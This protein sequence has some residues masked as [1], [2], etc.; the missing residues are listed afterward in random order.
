MSGSARHDIVIEEGATFVLSVS[1]EDAAEQVVNLTGASA[2][3]QGRVQWRDDATLFSL[4]SGAGDIVID[5]AAG[6]VTAT[7]SD[8]A[9]AAYEFETGVYDLEVVEADGTVLRVCYG[10]VELSREVTR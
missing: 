1:L 2:R 3:M 6:S 10:V 4:T 7:I 9:T 8:T 5:G